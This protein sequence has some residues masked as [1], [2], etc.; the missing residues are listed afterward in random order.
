MKAK[1][2]QSLNR[3]NKNSF[4]R[5]PGIL[6]QYSKKAAYFYTKISM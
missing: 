4:G 2:L 5:L 6:K 3:Q 1:A